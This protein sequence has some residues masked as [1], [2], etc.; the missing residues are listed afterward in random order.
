MNRRYMLLFG[1][2]TWGGV[3]VLCLLLVAIGGRTHFH[4][5]APN[6]RPDQCETLHV[7]SVIREPENTWSNSAYLLAGVFIL[8]RSPTL[9]GRVTGACF[10]A[11]CFLSG[12]YHASV[13]DPWQGGDI[14]GVYAVLLALILFGTWGMTERFF[15]TISLPFL[16]SI[17]KCASIT[18]AILLAALMAHYRPVQP[19]N[20]PF[21]SDIVFTVIISAL[22]ALQG[23]IFV[24]SLWQRDTSTT[25][26]RKLWVRSSPV[27]LILAM[28]GL[29]ALFLIAMLTRP[30]AIVALLGGV[31]LL[32]GA[33]VGFYFSSRA[34][35]RFLSFDADVRV[36]WLEFPIMAALTGLAVLFRKGDG[37]SNVFCSPG[38]IVQAHALWHILSAAT[39]LLAYDSFARL[40]PQDER[41]CILPD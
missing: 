22:V 15:G 32:A 14:F 6:G 39:L 1:S 27:L 35:L 33:G 26:L 29:L 36:M 11:L 2:L 31:L 34:S 41:A 4:W 3:L 16:R 25:F 21:D 38:S 12:I 23:A 18:C 8:F 37:P 20:G 9:L 40:A 19:I 30:S 10:C 28:G 17:L 7:D 13:A 5:G 24:I